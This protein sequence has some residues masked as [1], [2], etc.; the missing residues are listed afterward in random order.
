MCPSSTGHLSTAIFHLPI[1]FQY[2]K[3]SH[4]V[5]VPENCWEQH[6]SKTLCKFHKTTSSYS[7]TNQPHQQIPSRGLTHPTC[8]KAKC[9]KIAW[10]YRSSEEGNNVHGNKAHQRWRSYIHAITLLEMDVSENTGVFPPKSSMDYGLIGV[11]HYYKPSILGG[12]PPNFWFNTPIRDTGKLPGGNASSRP[13]WLGACD[14]SRRR[15]PTQSSQPQVT[16]M[17]YPPWN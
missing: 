10:G 16:T 6:P 14:R 4:Q 15:G 17:G 5:C 9:S 8:G 1:W 3:H 7:R 12:F 2:T 13:T 11:F